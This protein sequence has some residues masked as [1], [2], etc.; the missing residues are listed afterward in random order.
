MPPEP[1]P[2]PEPLLVELPTPDIPPKLETLALQ[3][4]PIFSASAAA[5]AGFG[6]TCDV[7]E[8]LARAFAEDSFI[9]GELARIGP[10]SR[11]VS[12]A[13]MFWDAQW[14]E[15]PGDPPKDAV[16][17]LRRGILEGV[18]AAPPG[19]LSQELAGPRFIF[20]SGAGSTLMLVIGSGTWRWEQLLIDAEETPDSPVLAQ[21]GVGN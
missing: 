3:A 19:C 20:V 2:T 6:T 4:Q 12:N 11:S 15:L 21:Q 7:A 14:V 1:E 16:E 9:K 5:H 18:R 8:T 10:Q 17:A 13:I